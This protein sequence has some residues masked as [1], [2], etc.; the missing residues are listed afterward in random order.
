MQRYIYPM[1]APP[2]P[3]QLEQDKL[4]VDESFNR[5][6]DLIDQL[7]RDTAAM[8]VSE[9]VRKE[10]LDSALSDFENAIQ[11]LKDASKRRDE[12]T[13]RI[14]DEVRNLQNMIP[15]AMKQQEE[16]ADE[17][18][19]DLNSE[20]KSLKTLLGNRMGGP[21]GNNTQQ[22]S[23]PMLN[24]AGPNQSS[25]VGPGINGSATGNAAG[26]SS[27]TSHVTNSPVPDS[28]NTSSPYGRFTSGKGGIPAWQMAASKKNESE[29]SANRDIPETSTTDRAASS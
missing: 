18:L 1:I 10:R 25:T 27:D 23:A 11:E 6:F 4:A 14:G 9:E 8:K 22:K 28:S 26:G 29:R 3:P 7:S 2:T 16:N 13:R 5:A 12:D 15:K 24:G 19:R 17:R 20:L 21:A